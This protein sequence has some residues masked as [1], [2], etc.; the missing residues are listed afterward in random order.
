MSKSVRVALCLALMMSFSFIPSA[1]ALTSVET[2]AVQSLEAS[3]SDPET[4]ERLD[5]A[6]QVVR[7]T[8]T[9]EEKV[10]LDSLKEGIT[11]IKAESAIGTRK[12]TKIGKLASKIG[13]GI[14]RLVAKSMRPFV[15][16]AG[17]LSGRYGK[18]HEFQE[19]GSNSVLNFFGR[20]A[21]RFKALG[22][23]AIASLLD[24]MS[25]GDQLTA[26][27]VELIIA[28]MPEL[29]VKDWEGL[30]AG[31]ADGISV[32][33][34]VDVT[35]KV[36]AVAGLGALPGIAFTGFAIGFYGSLIPCMADKALDRNENLARYCEG[37]YSQYMTIVV[38]ARMKGYLRGIHDWNSSR[39][40]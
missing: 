11:E 18:H 12:Q 37:I 2:T 8:A 39:G 31:V 40:R 24:R 15:W 1:R 34:A 23:D 5:Q 35:G 28:A 16:G 29:D 22:N 3:L 13:I 10:I 21:N 17:Y 14:N 38:P 26:A 4:L 7:E 9:P 6:I 36:L 19:D 32:G 27:E 33:I 20:L 30:S 25:K